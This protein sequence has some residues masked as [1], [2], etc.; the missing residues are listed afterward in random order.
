M[1]RWIVALTLAVSTLAAAAAALAGGGDSIAN[2]PALSYDTQQYGN[3]GGEYY[4]AS[5]NA[6]DIL[7]ITYRPTD[8]G[9]CASVHLY[10]PTE[11]DAA[12]QAA[13]LDADAVATDSGCI[14]KFRMLKWT[15]PQAGGWIVRVDTTNGSPYLLNGYAARLTRLTL[16]APRRAAAGR[17]ITVRG[18]LTGATGSVALRLSGP[19]TLLRSRVRVSAAGLYAWKPK[20][21]RAG[22]YVVT[23]SYAGDG[24]HL[25]SRARATLT[26][27]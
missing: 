18:K 25:P 15:A 11:T 22:A 17:T 7:T 12:L 1:R 23:A 26:V 2:A 19:G 14:T 21:G 10:P 3:P 6:G 8:P 4:R 24:T 20:V 27:A 13:G 9:A 16:A 5:L